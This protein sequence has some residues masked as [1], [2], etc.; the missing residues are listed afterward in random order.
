MPQDPE[1][2]LSIGHALKTQGQTLDAIEAYRTATRVKPDCG[3]AY[4]SLANLKTYRFTEGELARMRAAEADPATRLADRYH[5]CFA[6][7]KAL[8]DRAV[9]AESFAYYERG[10]AL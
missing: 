9:Y 6:L 7:G 3:D 2:H 1:L 10:N 4:W 5:L 8:E